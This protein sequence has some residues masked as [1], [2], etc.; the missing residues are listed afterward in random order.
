MNGAAFGVG[1]GDSAFQRSR[2]WVARRAPAASARSFSQTISSATSPSP[3]AVAKP[4]SGVGEH[5]PRVAHGLGGELDAVGD[6]LGMLDV[7]GG[8]VDD[9]GDEQHAGGQ[10][11]AA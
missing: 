4:Q 10:G 8:R 6:D 9:A 3:A 5:A 2:R 1:H 11:I 7:V